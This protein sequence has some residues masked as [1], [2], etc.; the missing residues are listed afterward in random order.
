MIDVDQEI[1]GAVV[2]EFFGILY[3]LHQ[4]WPTFGYFQVRCQFFQ[5]LLLI[6]EGKPIGIFFQKKVKGIDSPQL[7]DDLYVDF[8]F[9]HLVGKN[10]PRQ[11]I[12][13]GILLPI[14][15]VRLWQDLQGI[16]GNFGARMNGRPEA[17]G[18][19]PEFDQTVVFVMRAVANRYF[20]GHG[21]KIFGHLSR[22]RQ[23]LKEIRRVKKIAAF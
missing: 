7:G 15:E 14:D 21:K 2:E 22:K 20:N 6:F 18:L 13:K 10:H 17:N 16:S 1:V 12:P 4:Q 9:F 23:H 5:Q 11:K 8:E 19:G 3:K